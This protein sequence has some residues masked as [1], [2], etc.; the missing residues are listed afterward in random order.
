MPT[1]YWRH[2]CRDREVVESHPVCGACGE[3]GT[4]DGWHLRMHEAMARYQYVFGLKPIGAHRRFADELLGSLRTTCPTCAGNSVVSAGTMWR[5]CTTCE[6]TGGFWT[7]SD[8]EV[9]AAR[10]EVLRIHPGTEALRPAAFIGVPLIHDLRGGV[11]V[12]AA[13]VERSTD[14]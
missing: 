13:D 2:Y 1:P 12:G 8:G 7:C 3:S 11:V 14:T 5:A 10:A 6:G 4:F 9:S